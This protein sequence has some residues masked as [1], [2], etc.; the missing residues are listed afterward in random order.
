[1]EMIVPDINFPIVVIACAFM[2]LDII[3]GLVKAASQGKI[4]ST[5]MKSGL[6]HKCGFMLVI[7]FG[8]LCDY[9][10]LYVDL[11]F[12]IPI[13]YAVCLY[14]IL[15]EITSILE[16]LAVISPEL[17]STKFMSIFDKVGDNK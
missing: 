9:A 16:N 2:V 12:N 7:V 8:I 6:F 11:G 15:T 14:V 3:T 1:M 4:D 17:A 10:M 13:L 5:V